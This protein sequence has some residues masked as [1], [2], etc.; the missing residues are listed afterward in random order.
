[1]A[2]TDEVKSRWSAKYLLGITNPQL[3]GA[4][5]IDEGR[6]LR[7]S[8]DV[9][10]EIRIRAAALFDVTDARHVAVA[11]EAVIAL[12]LVRVGGKGADARWQAAMKRIDLLGKVTGHDRLLPQITRADGTRNVPGEVPIFADREWDDLILDSRGP[13]DDAPDDIFDRP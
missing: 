13:R 2:L 7:A 11:V 8:D 6:L 5:V 4:T 12:L 9:E 10:G 3:A 1:M